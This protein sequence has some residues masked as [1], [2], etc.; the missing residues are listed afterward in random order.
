MVKTLDESMNDPN[1]EILLM[2]SKILEI[3]PLKTADTVTYAKV[4]YSFV[5]TLKYVETDENPAPSEE[6]IT[7]TT[8]IF[9]QMYGDENVSF[10]SQKSMN[11]TYEN[12][13][14]AFSKDALPEKLEKL[15]KLQNKIQTLILTVPKFKSF[16]SIMAKYSDKRL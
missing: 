11:I 9:K 3:S 1:L 16:F 10:D 4:G 7:M 2:D 5:M 8:N 14:P 12:L 13:R 15:K 6:V